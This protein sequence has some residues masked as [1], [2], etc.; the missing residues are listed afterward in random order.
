MPLHELTHVDLDQRV[1]AA[2]HELG[3]RAGQQ[4]LADTSRP[5]KDEAADRPPR[6]LQPGASAT[7]CLGHR[8]DRLVLP[9]DSL[10]QRLLHVEQSLAFLRRQAH[11]RNAGPH[12]DDL[13]DILV[14]DVRLGFVLLVAP[15]LLRD[16]RCGFAAFAPDHADRR[17]A[18]TPGQL[19]A[20]SSSLRS[21]SRPRF[22]SLR[23]GGDAERY[24]RTR[25]A[26]SSIRSIALSGRNRSVT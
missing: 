5:E 10:V 13:S 1:L 17:P 20:A 12:R 25:D 11:Q 21:D 6:I 24:M 18:R 9:D 15:V 3:Q 26:A 23:L 14:G 16:R 8:C 2:E 19:T 7:N 22:A 4:R